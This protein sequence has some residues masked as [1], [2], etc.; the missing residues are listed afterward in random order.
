MN[1][2]LI[3]TW[4]SQQHQSRRWTEKWVPARQFDR[5]LFPRKQVVHKELMM[6]MMM[7]MY[8]EKEKVVWYTTII[9]KVA[10][11]DE[12]TSRTCSGRP[13]SSVLPTNPV[14]RSVCM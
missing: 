13:V 3:R 9:G 14:C 1:D 6:M 10:V 2:N 7:K 11:S 8:D 5:P 12:L 4:G